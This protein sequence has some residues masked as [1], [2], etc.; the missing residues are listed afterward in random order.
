M[1]KI[2]EKP[3]IIFDANYDN[4]DKSHIPKGHIPRYDPSHRR[5]NLFIFSNGIP[6]DEE[7]YDLVFEWICSE[8]ELLQYDWVA[9]HDNFPIVTQRVLDILLKICPNDFQYF[10]VSFNGR[11]QETFSNLVYFGEGVEDITFHRKG[12]YLINI[13]HQVDAIDIKNCIKGTSAMNSR[14]LF[15]GAV[16]VVLKEG[17]MGEHHLA[18]SKTPRGAQSGI[19]SNMELMSP[20]LARE[21]KKHNF[22]FLEFFHDDGTFV[23]F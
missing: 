12:Y 4:E 3:Y 15:R 10:P 21:L 16:K 9:N 19:R 22:K 13:I 17:C 2:K 5:T 20:F 1:K 14:K 23:Q 8:E 18:R 6:V 7:D 11:S